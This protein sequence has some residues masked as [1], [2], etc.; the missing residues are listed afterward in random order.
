MDIKNATHKNIIDVVDEFDYS[1]QNDNYNDS[2]IKWRKNKDNPFAFNFS[3]NKNES[4]F[5]EGKGFI[6]DSFM[7]SEYEIINR[8]FFILGTAMLLWVAI[9]NIIGKIIIYILDIMEVDIH[10]KFF[11][12]SYYGGS[13]QV[14][15]VMIIITLIK[16]YVPVFYLHYKLKMPFK[17]EFMSTMN[18]PIELI[19]SIAIS[20][21]ICTVINIPDAYSSSAKEIYSYFKSIS[22]DVSVWGQTE[23]I[24]YTVFDV[25]IL[26]ISSEILFRGAVFSALRQF[27]D[28]FAI[29]VTSVVA[30]L[31]TQNFYDMMVMF[32][33]SIIS[34][35][36]MLKSGSI[37]TSFAVSIVFKMYQLTIVIIEASNSENMFFI[38]N[39]TMIAIFVAG[40]V[41]ITMTNIIQR[42]HKRKYFA[43]Y[44]SEISLKERLI[45]SFKSF[46]FTAI[47]II[48]IM[49]S[50]IKIIY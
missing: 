33:I 40:I 5:I 10:T 34:S 7:A 22:T 35:V 44:T 1:T 21:V 20:L 2:F 41:T 9:D 46:P 11:G 23:Y 37:F 45:Y 13:V 50:I 27:G 6:N 3:A 4:L 8:I 26:S 17:V 31:L 24:I 16:I 30:A 25:I 12:M 42:N 32:V 15:T 36:G 29:I 38:R 14:V 47:S 39:F 49:A 19:S 18:H 43:K 48:C 28:I